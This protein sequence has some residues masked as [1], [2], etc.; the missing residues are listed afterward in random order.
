MQSTD[1]QEKVDVPR[2][3]DKIEILFELEGD[4]MYWWPC[5]VLESS[6]LPSSST[7]RGTATVEYAARHKSGKQQE[8][9]IFLA[10]RKVTTSTGDTPW[11]TSDEAA[12]A[13]D[14]DEGD[15]DWEFTGAQRSVR[16]RRNR[17]APGTDEDDEENE[18]RAE[19]ENCRGKRDRVGDA[20]HVGEYREHVEA[21]NDGR[22]GKRRKKRG[23]REVEKPGLSDEPPMQSERNTAPQGPSGLDELR[24]EIAELRGK[25]EDNNNIQLQEYVKNKVGEKITIWCMQ[26]R[27]ELARA[28]RDMKANGR[29]PFSAAV[30]NSSVNVKDTTSYETFTEVIRCMLEN[31]GGGQPRGVSFIPSLSDLLTPHLDIKEGHVVFADAG[32]ILRWLGM[33]SACD[34]KRALQKSQTL[35]NGAHLMRVLGGLQEEGDEDGPL[36]LFVGSSCAAKTEDAHPELGCTEARAIEFDTRRWDSSNNML[37]AKPEFRMRKP[38]SFDGEKDFARAKESVF[39]LSWSWIKGLEGRAFSDHARSSRN[40]RLGVV[41]VHL[42]Y[43]IFKGRETCDTVRALLK[44]DD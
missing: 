9:V 4:E 23:N 40:Y 7:V 39:R 1:Q 26:V 21:G 17:R 24:A 28:V 22:S 19:K 29:K 30:H 18:F 14:G 15:R 35:R 36:R 31:Q 8:K 16:E 41:S 33:G 34:V 11:R 5:V 20:V 43:V 32:T 6:E 10:D 37:A 27:C 42:P 44:V 3:F 13:G 2:A 12:D 25:V 38:G